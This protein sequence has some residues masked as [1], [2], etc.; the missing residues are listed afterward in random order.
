MTWAVKQPLDTQQ[1][2]DVKNW[3]PG[4][5]NIKTLMIAY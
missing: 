1:G 4:R 3:S 5:I 2:G